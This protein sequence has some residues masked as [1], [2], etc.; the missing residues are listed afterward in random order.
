VKT[1]GRDKIQ[2]AALP[3]IVDPNGL[4][5]VLLLTSRETRRW[6]IPKGWPIR[7]LKPRDVAVREAFEEAGLT[8]KIIGKRPVGS[9]RYS[10]LLTPDVQIPCDVG[11]FLFRVDQQA[12]EWPEKGQRELQWLRPE[13][14]AKMVVEEELAEIIRRV[15]RQLPILLMR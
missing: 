2:F 9:Y 15:P 13:E 7:G 8:G 6:V 11:V 10:K 14:A 12:N 5:Q 3:F 1:N 4:V